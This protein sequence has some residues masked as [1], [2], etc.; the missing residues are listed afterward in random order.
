MLTVTPESDTLIRLEASGTIDAAA[1]EKGLEELL[2]LTRDRERVNMLYIVKGI[3]MPELSALAVEMKYIA[4]LFGLLRKMRRV[5]VVSDQGWVR[6]AAEIEGALIPGLRI[7]A[8]DAREEAAAR[9]WLALD[10]DDTGATGTTGTTAKTQ[11]KSG[12]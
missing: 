5:A 11:E 12:A 10:D 6:T 4:R 9:A 2:R 1:M 3:T 7:K 8:F